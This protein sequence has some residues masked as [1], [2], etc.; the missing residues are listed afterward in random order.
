M[1]RLI[2]TTLL[3]E[4]NAEAAASPRRRRNHNFHSADDH[5]AHRLLNAIEPGSYVAPHRH[6]ETA[7]DET[8]LVLKG[9]LGLVIFDDG[10]GVVQTVVLAAT[11]DVRGVDIPHDTW[12]SLVALE[13]GT[14]FFETK[15]G[16]YRALTVEERA[17]WA[18][19]ENDGAAAKYL[20]QLE[21][22]FC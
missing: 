19:A 11:G 2:D 4:L 7:K 20:R 8:M 9:R 21:Q 15:A 22:H 1:I 17:P 13:T 16:P 3:G 10:G 18:P 5:P 14:V 12:H 6:L